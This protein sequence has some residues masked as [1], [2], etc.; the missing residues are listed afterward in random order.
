MGYSSTYGGVIQNLPPLSTTDPVD[1]SAVREGL[2]NGLMHACDQAG[3]VLVARTP[4]TV[5]EQSSPSTSVYRRMIDC[6][7]VPLRCTPSGAS[8]LLVPYLRASI[9]AAGTASFLVQVVFS[10]SSMDVPRPGT[11][12]S[13]EVTTTSTTAADIDFTAASPESMRLTS[14]TMESQAD[15]RLPSLDG[16]GEASVGRCMRV[17]IQ[18]WAKTSV[19]TSLPRIHAFGV[20][21]YW[22]T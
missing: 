12:W 17:A 19:L 13:I 22:A 4:V 16:A 21:E 15:E 3:Q 6:R 20:R 11:D 9:S 14:F 1:T 8:Y 7:Q 5:Y 2:I 18:V 10:E